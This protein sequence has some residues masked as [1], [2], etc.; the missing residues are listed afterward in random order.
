[1]RVVLFRHGP[2]GERDPAK[3]P[4]DAQRPLTAKGEQ[5]TAA[6]AA[7]LRRLRPDVRHLFT[8]PLLRAL[9]TTQIVARVLALHGPVE[10]WEELSGGV[11]LR[12]VVA[13]LSQVPPSS[14]IVLVGHEPDLG[15]LAGSLLFGETR[16]IPLRKAGACCLLFEDTPRAGGAH[17]QW[18]ASPRMLRL[19]GRTKGRS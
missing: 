15:R 12:E 17:L 4:D 13:R 6:A 7:G 16:A 11:P 5:R 8:S 9:Q 14:T 10:T 2:A 1:M 18:V 3:W 19:I